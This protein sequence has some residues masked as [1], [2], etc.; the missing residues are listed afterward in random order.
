MSELE[1]WTA[2]HPTGIL[3]V[4]DRWT[5]KIAVFDDVRDQEGDEVSGVLILEELGSCL[6]SPA[7]SLTQM[8]S[9]IGFGAQKAAGWRSCLRQCQRAV[10]EMRA[11]GSV[12][13]GG[14]YDASWRTHQE[15]A[16]RLLSLGQSQAR[17]EG[18]EVSSLPDPVYPTVRARQSHSATKAVPRPFREVIAESVR[19]Q[20]LKNLAVGARNLPDP[21]LVH[22]LTDIV[23]ELRLQYDR[24]LGPDR[25]S[26][27]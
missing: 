1:R 25:N 7:L 16:S 11:A 17:L 13:S 6:A 3:T 10:A 27:L 22:L 8:L 4:N 23:R 19:M 20:V 14:R 9:R 12:L 2:E 5:F 21:R 24:C 15:A 18:V 26:G